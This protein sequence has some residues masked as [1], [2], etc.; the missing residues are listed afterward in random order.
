MTS[1]FHS[2]GAYWEA[3]LEH[4]HWDRLEEAFHELDAHGVGDAAAYLRWYRVIEAEVTTRRK[5]VIFRVNDWLQFEY[6]PD[7]IMDL[8]DTLVGRILAGCDDIAS[9]LR[10]QHSAPTMISILA[11]E[12]DG[13]WAMSPYGYCIP[14]E[15]Y[16]K[17]CLP[18]HLVDDPEEFTQ[19]VAHEYAHVISEVLSDGHAPRWLEEALS[20]LAERQ[21]D[22]DTHQAFLC[23][24]A[25]W[26][27]PADLEWALE[28]PG[29]E[30]DETVIWNAY[31][32]C[33]WIGLYLASLGPES[34][35]SDLL[36]EHGNESPVKNLMLALSN[37]TRT[38]AAFQSVYRLSVDEL[39]E[40]AYQWLLNS[41]VSPKESPS[42]HL[43]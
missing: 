33:G 43:Y 24:Q 16:D 9:R 37:R 18:N 41:P 30:E 26:L 27:S 7:E 11:E 5:S 35:F 25:D 36:R 13:P 31:Q 1:P 42:S 2:D 21:V 40:N 32:Q 3:A 38:D 23:E 34:K 6:V 12:T 20:V 15:D 19:A 39:F 10:W 17:I 29:P 8:R 14:K 22:P 28:N 4:Y